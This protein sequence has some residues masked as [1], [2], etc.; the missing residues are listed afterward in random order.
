MRWDVGNG[1]SRTYVGGLDDIL[2][3][4]INIGG[5]H[6]VAMELVDETALRLAANE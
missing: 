1:L 3:V 5:D 6:D 4:A 2:A